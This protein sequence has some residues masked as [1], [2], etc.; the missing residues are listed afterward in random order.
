MA[1]RLEGVR[2]LFAGWR[3]VDSGLR[4]NWRRRSN[5]PLAERQCRNFLRPRLTR[6]WLTRFLAPLREVAS[7]WED[8]QELT[9]KDEPALAAATVV[10]LGVSNVLR[11]CR[12]RAF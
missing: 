7:R 2:P 11:S 8:P 4:V 1:R 6:A 10:K 9:Q 3:T 5:R 12:R